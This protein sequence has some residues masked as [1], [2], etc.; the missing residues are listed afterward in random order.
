MVPRVTINDET[1]TDAAGV[2]DAFVR[3]VR[4]AHETNGHVKLLPPDH[5]AGEGG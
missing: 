4:R 3:A 2:N 1:P 5:T